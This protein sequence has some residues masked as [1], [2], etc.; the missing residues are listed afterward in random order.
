MKNRVL[1]AQLQ[2]ELLGQDTKRLL[3]IK[4]HTDNLSRFGEISF[5]F[6]IIA[7]KG[8]IREQIGGIKNQNILEYYLKRKDCDPAGL[9]DDDIVKKV[10]IMLR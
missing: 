5:P 2:Q 4:T 7:W 8:V 10:N 3:I 1:V 9:S 6:D